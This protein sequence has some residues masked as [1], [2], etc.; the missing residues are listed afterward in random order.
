MVDLE[1]IQEQL[2]AAVHL[3]HEAVATPPFTCF[4]NPDSDAPYAN[5]AIPDR[6][7]DATDAP[8]LAELERV[9]ADRNCRPRFE[10]LE[11]YAPHFAAVLEGRGYH[12]KMRSLLMVCTP[13]ALRKP[14]WPPALTIE[15]LTDQTQIETL[16]DMMTVQARA[17]GDADAPRTTAEE[18]R[19]FRKRFAA[20]QMFLARMGETVVSAASLTA[21]YKGVSELAGVGTLPAFRRRG[22]ATAL[23]FAATESAFAQGVTQVFL[24]AAN[25]EAGRVYAQV[26]FAACGS[27][28]VYHL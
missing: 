8:A 27:G 3:S 16:Q 17:F 25:A 18:A 7:V 23:T 15:T 9:F 26:G 4:F 12:C 19:Q 2:R 1:L 21:P 22:I 13:D 20:L 14:A 11:D 24:T 28:L 5:Y 6:P 10:F